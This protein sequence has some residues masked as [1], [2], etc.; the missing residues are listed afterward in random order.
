MVAGVAESGLSWQ[1][2]A[3]A[4]AVADRATGSGGTPDFFRV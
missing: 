3:H 1:I 2:A 4:Y